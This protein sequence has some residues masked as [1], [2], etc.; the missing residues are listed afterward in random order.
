MFIFVPN[1]GN[2]WKSFERFAE[3]LRLICQTCILSAQMKLIWLNTY[4]CFVWTISEQMAIFLAGVSKFHSNCQDEVWRIIKN[5][6]AK[7]SS[8]SKYLGNP[9][10]KNSFGEF[11]QSVVKKGTYMSRRNSWWKI[12][13]LKNYLFFQCISFFGEINLETW[14]SCFVQSYK[15]TFYMSREFFLETFLKETFFINTIG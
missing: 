12:I 6:R 5:F 9:V 15:I 2:F 14:R 4:S 7:Q 13:F 8:S 1:F 10:E 11:F 3:N